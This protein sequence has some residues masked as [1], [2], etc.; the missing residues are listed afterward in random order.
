[1][2]EPITNATTQFPTTNAT[3]IATTTSM[4]QPK[5]ATH[6]QH[7]Y[8]YRDHS[9]LFDLDDQTQ[10]IDESIHYVHPTNP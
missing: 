6:Q 10:Q 3:T 7:P 1:M 2:I 5:H 8:Q 9:K 4:N